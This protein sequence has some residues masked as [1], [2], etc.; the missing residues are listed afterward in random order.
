MTVKLSCFTLEL[1][2][3][4]IIDVI[5]SFQ[6]VQNN[7]GWRNGFTEIRKFGKNK[8]FIRHTISD[9]WTVMNY[10]EAPIFVKN[11]LRLNGY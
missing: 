5:K 3:I 10:E 1:P 9:K 7:K 2:S 6:F 11:Y 8:Y 4:D